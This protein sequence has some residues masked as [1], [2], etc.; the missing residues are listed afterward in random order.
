MQIETLWPHCL[1][2]LQ[3]NLGASQF[4]IWIKPLSA[5]MI[6]DTLVIAVPNQIFLQFI[7]DRYL[8]MIEMAAAKLCAG[9]PPPIEL[10]VGQMSA[11]APRVAARSAN[12]ASDE[13]APAAAVAPVKT[14][15]RFDAGGASHETT[16]L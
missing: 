4:N 10:K 5:Q 12:A 6:D 13:A 1:N 3:Q 11:P 9:V 7:R 2:E 8:G 15:K 14:G 16:R